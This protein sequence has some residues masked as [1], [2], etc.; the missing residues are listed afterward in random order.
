MHSFKIV[1][2]LRKC[3]IHFNKGKK[4]NP[5][6]CDVQTEEKIFHDRKM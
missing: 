5:E 4:S 2:E 3:L 1:I 6:D